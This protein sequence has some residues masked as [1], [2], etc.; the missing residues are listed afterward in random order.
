[1]GLLTTKKQVTHEREILQK[2]KRS[3]TIKHSE[4]KSE[5]IHIQNG[6][7]YKILIKIKK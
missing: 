5:A 6:E 1:M 4:A 2:S 3:R 7:G